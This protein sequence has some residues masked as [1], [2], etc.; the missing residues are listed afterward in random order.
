[1]YSKE[2]LTW[3]AKMLG[4]SVPA[5]Q[6]VAEVESGGSGFDSEGRCKI[7]F[8]GHL[9]NKFTHG[10]Y[11]S[12]HP[13]LA[14]ENWQEARGYYRRDQWDRFSQAYQLDAKAAIKATSWG[15]FQILGMNYVG[16]G[17]PSPEVMVTAMSDG[18]GG[19]SAEEEHL[20]SF[21]NF[22]RYN[23][24]DRYLRLPSFEQFAL[25]YYGPGYKTYSYDARLKMA[26]LKYN[27]A[28]S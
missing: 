5:V 21:V 4:C 26:F 8:E 11:R 19:R 12:A 2:L 27:G 20:W 28:F 17:Y 16:C 3:A 6:A 13:D 22:L 10:K 7:L 1:M 18:A 24:F 9:F 15:T 25:A 23:K 14:C